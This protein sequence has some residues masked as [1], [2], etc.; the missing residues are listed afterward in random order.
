M[1]SF[2]GWEAVSHLAGELRDP[3]PPA[4]ARDLRR[5]GVVV[6]LYLGLA[7]GDDRR[8]RHARRPTCRSPT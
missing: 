8:A 3:A 6:V 2:I 1:L 5:A 4:P 7:V